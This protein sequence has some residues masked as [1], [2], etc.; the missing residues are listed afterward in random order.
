MSTPYPPE[1]DEALEPEVADSIVKENYGQKDAW[2]GCFDAWSDE[3]VTALF[4][5]LWNEM[6]ER[7]LAWEEVPFDV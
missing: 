7:K 1:Y 4:R 6:Y 2:P 5:N 3:E